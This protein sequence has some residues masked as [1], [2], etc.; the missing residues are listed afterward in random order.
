MLYF[1]TSRKKF[2]KIERP[3]LRVAASNDFTYVTSEVLLCMYKT[4]TDHTCTSLS[5]LLSY[6]VYKMSE[7]RR[8]NE[9]HRIDFSFVIIIVIIEL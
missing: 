8:T 6:E 9:Y 2:E 3:T 4:S 5:Y 7:E 1:L